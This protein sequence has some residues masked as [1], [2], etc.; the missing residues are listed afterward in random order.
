MVGTTQTFNVVIDIVNSSG[1]ESQPGRQ[2]WLTVIEC[3]SAAGDKIPPYIIFKGQNLMTSWLLENLPD[4]WQFAANAS[5]WT[6]NFHGMEWIKHF[7]ASTRHNLRSPTE[8]RLLLCDGHDSHV[9][10]DFVSFCI[11]NRIDLVLLPPH[12]SHLLQ[13]L[14]VGIFSPLKRAISK[15]ILRLLRSGIARI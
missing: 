13:P 6:N 8:Y 3:I 5:G 2:E 4:G 10:A 15:R 12:S 11:E 9:S 1:Y 7:E 14:D